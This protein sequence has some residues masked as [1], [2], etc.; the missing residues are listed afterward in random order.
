LWCPHVLT[1]PRIPTVGALG[2]AKAEVGVQIVERWIMGRLRHEL[3]F[4]LRQLNER[5]RELLVD[6]N[7]R[8]MKKQPGSRQSQFETLDKPALK[9]LPSMAYTYTQVTRVRVHLDYHVEIEKHY[10]SVPHALIKQQLEAPI[11]GQL[12]TLYHQGQQGAVHPRS[13]HVGRHTTVEAHMPTA[14]QKQHQWS[15]PRF[16]R[17]ASDIGPATE[18]LVGQ[19]LYAKKHPEQSYRVCLGLLS[20]AKKYASK[21]LEAACYRALAMAIAR[22]A[23]IPFSLGKKTGE[24]SSPGHTNRAISRHRTQKHSWQSLLSIRRKQVTRLS[25]IQSVKTKRHT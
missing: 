18:K 17:W 21:R 8:P 9:S 5:I 23:G 13:S 16:E 15:P 22:L 6:L 10:Y 4:S 3:F 7:G 20:R 25:T 11:T 24:P 1:S 14:H 2:E 12:V 19:F